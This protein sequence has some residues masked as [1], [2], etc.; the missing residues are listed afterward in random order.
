MFSTNGVMIYIVNKEST[1]SSKDDQTWLSWSKSFTERAVLLSMIYSLAVLC[2]QPPGSWTS[3]REEH[4]CRHQSHYT[5]DTEVTFAKAGCPWLWNVS[6][7]LYL[8]RSTARCVALAQI[9]DVAALSLLELSCW[10]VSF[11]QIFP[12]HQIQVREDLMEQPL[13]NIHKQF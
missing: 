8:C 5:S 13:E 2:D 4:Y 10:Q 11:R 12:K 6:D 9:Q 1:F 3:H 7:L